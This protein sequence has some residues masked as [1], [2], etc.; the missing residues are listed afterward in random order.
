LPTLRLPLKD[1]GDVW[2]L[3]GDHVKDDTGKLMGGS[4]HGPGRTHAG[5]HSAEVVS[6][7]TV[8]AV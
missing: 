2:L 8:A 1:G 4:S 5:F 6:E 3:G 7:K